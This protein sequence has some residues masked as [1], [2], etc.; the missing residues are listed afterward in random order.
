M[1]NLPISQLP[2]AASLSG[3]EIFAVVQNGTTTQ[4]TTENI[5][6]YIFSSG[7]NS[8]DLGGV[9]VRTL[10]ARNGIVYYDPSPQT[11]VDF[12]SGSA[13]SIFGSRNI[14]SSF[15]SNTDYKS[16]ILHFRTFG[17]FG[18]SNNDNISVKLQIG[19]N[20]LAS[21]NIGTLPL[22]QPD[23][24]S[25]EILGEII[26]TNGQATVCYSLGH[27]DN[28]GDYKRYPLSNALTP[29]TITGLSGGDFKIIISGSTEIALTSS[30]AYLQVWS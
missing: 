6:N 29:D 5:A 20:V 3:S 8:D 27:C 21:S 17:K 19:N 9:A 12:N 11:D 30:A 22:S 16:K 14:P 1:P 18:G 4:T 7:S 25:F 26:L 15:L 10:Y 13:S 24:H 28:Q 2:A 23:N